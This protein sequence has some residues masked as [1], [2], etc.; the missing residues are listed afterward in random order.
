MVMR[1]M[2]DQAKLRLWIQRCDEGK[3]R[4]ANATVNVKDMSLVVSAAQACKH[5]IQ[6]RLTYQDSMPVK[7]RYFSV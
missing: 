3:I 2:S 6:H 5:V 7:G 4:S 1:V